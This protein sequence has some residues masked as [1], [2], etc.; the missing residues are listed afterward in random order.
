MIPSWSELEGNT[1]EASFASGTNWPGTGSGTNRL[2]SDALYRG[3]AVFTGVGNSPYDLSMDACA[4][5]FISF[6]SIASKPITNVK[7]IMAITPASVARQAG[8]GPPATRVA[9]QSSH[10]VLPVFR[11]RRREFHQAINVTTG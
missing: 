8:T 10:G 6:R 11:K 7:A 1:A 3:A 4:S 5:R 2:R 9:H